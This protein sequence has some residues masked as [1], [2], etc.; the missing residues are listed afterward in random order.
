MLEE[1]SSLLELEVFTPWGVKIG[2]LTNLE[3]DSESGEIAN[4][5]IEETNDRLVDGGN[6]ILIP[7]RWI[8]AVGD[9]VILRH[10]PVELPIKSQEELGE[11]NY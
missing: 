9:I 3:I 5:F 4:I 6:S 11:Y 10:F 2:D 7:Y 8:Q 1:A